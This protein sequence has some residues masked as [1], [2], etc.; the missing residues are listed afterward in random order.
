MSENLF[1]TKQT[2]LT[3][4]IFDKEPGV[5]GIGDLSLSLGTDFKAV[6]YE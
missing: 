6:T 4:S 5:R 3:V 2:S 1:C